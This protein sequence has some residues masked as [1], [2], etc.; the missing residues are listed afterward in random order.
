MLSSGAGSL[1]QKKGRFCKEAAFVLMHEQGNQ[2]NDRDRH[3]EKEQ[4]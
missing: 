2:D 1:P 4:Q 3:P